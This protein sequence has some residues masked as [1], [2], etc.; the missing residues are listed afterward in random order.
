MYTVGKCKV[1]EI[2]ATKRMTQKDLSVKTGIHKQHIS[3]Y[4]NNR[5]KMNLATAKTIASALD[6][7]I[8]DLYEWHFIE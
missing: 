4:V 2:L 8:D 1:R 6:C 3:A 5:R 7:S